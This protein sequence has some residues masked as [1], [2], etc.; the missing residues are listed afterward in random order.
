MRRRPGWPAAVPS[1]ERDSRGQLGAREPRS[2]RWEAGAATVGVGV[3]GDR[4]R[5]A[6]GR[7]RAYGGRRGAASR[8]ATGKSGGRGRAGDAGGR[9]GNQQSDQGPRGAPRAARPFGQARPGGRLRRRRR[10]H[11][12]PGDFSRASARTHSHLM[13]RRPAAGRRRRTRRL[14]TRAARTHAAYRRTRPPRRRKGATGR[15]THA[16]A[17]TRGGGDRRGARPRWPAGSLIATRGA[18][19]ATRRRFLA[20]GVGDGRT[21]DSPAQSRFLPT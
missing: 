2:K 16:A 5:G 20:M 1:R 4:A 3:G 10:R 21:A 19:Q 6:R 13:T 8:R 11:A 17:P 14:T 9:P 7:P 15:H 12:T 18:R